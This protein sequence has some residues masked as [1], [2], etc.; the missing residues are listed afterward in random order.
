MGRDGGTI[1]NI[2]LPFYLG[3]G[4]RLGSGNQWFPWI[5]VE[6]VAGI[7]THAVESDPV[8]GVL[9]AVA[10]ATNTNSEFTAAFAKALNRPACIPVPEFALNLIYGSVRAKAILEG[11]K[12]IPKKTLESG[13]QFKYPNLEAACK[14]FAHFF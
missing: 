6:D 9:N 11:Q 3:V 1:Q 7:I 10:P 2:I 14:E 8:T 5:H 12:V 13:Y 4:G